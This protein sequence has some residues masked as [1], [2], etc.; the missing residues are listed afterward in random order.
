MLSL[1]IGNNNDRK[2]FHLSISQYDYKAQPAA[3]HDQISQLSNADGD[4]ILSKDCNY[5][6]LFGIISSNITLTDT[7]HGHCIVWLFCLVSTCFPQTK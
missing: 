1:L 3:V 5:I 7:S 6:L 2:L 4:M